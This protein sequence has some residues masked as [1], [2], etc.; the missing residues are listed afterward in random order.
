[1]EKYHSKRTFTFAHNNRTAFQTIRFEYGPNTN[2]P[3]SLFSSKRKRTTRVGMEEK[4]KF[5]RA[6]LL[7]EET[8][9]YSRMRNETGT[10]YTSLR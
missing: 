10:R 9:I 8:V 6:I 4:M 3:E 1:M 7:A 5:I 2:R